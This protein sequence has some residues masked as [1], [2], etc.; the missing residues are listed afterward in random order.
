MC[1]PSGVD[2]AGGDV[3]HHRGRAAALGVDEEVGAGMRG[4][5]R[6]DVARAD[7]GVDVALAVPH[8]HRA[9]RALLDVGA[10]E[11]V[12]AEQDLGVLAVLAVDV[13]DDRDGVRRG[14]AVVG[15]GL[16]LG[17]RVDVHHDDRAGV[18]RLP[19]AQL[20]G[21]DRVGE[22]AAGVGV[23]QQHRLVRAQDRGGLGHE[24]DAAEGD[25][26]GARWPP[27]AARGR[28]S[29]RRSRPRPGP[30][31]AGSC[32]RGS[33]R[34]ARAASARTSACSGGDV[35]ELEQGH[36]SVSRSRERSRAGRRV[37]ERAH[38]DVV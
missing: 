12:G 4:A 14:D 19:R 32:G 5:H 24:V 35:V 27:P 11:H 9:A 3:L 7:A 38:R 31:A 23:G 37:R 20:L 13:L 30:R 17:G 8:V 18:P 26:V 36:G 2:V 29:R 21:G 6:R 33:R 25:H 15:L 28:A 34:R 16:H 22:R 10:E 1:T